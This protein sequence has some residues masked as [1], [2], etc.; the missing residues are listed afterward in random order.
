M[1]LFHERASQIERDI[2]NVE[3]SEQGIHPDRGLALLNIEYGGLANACQ[4]RKGQL[5]QAALL[6][7][8]ANGIP[9]GFHGEFHA[10]YSSFTTI[11]ARRVFLLVLS[12]TISQF[13]L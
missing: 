10:W 6:S 11:A 7:M 5:T 4:V 3:Y 13:L 1:P 12:S 2:Q 9:N 8:K